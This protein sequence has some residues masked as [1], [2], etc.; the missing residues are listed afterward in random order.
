V[1]NRLE[2]LYKERAYLASLIERAPLS[3]QALNRETWVAGLDGIDAE[4]D[5]LEDE[6][7]DMLRAIA[8]AT[9]FQALKECYEDEQIVEILTGPSFDYDRRTAGQILDEVRRE[10]HE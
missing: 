2:Q 7:A 9:V 4:I 6:Q 10:H 8:A 5:H 1:N 3:T